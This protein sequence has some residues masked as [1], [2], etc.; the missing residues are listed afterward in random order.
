MMYIHER[1]IVNGKYTDYLGLVEDARS[2]GMDVTFDCYTYP[3]SGTSLTILLPHWT[4]DGGPEVLIEHL[5]S[6]KSRKKIAK[7]MPGMRNEEIK[8]I[9][10]MIYLEHPERLNRLLESFLSENA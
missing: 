8:D 7:E 3:Y 1:N 5:K 10:H 4:K 6:T 9:G 2:G